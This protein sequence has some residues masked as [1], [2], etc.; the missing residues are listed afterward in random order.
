MFPGLL[1]CYSSPVSSPRISFNR[2]VLSYWSASSAVSGVPM[3]SAADFGT[4]TEAL[5]SLFPLGPYAASGIQDGEGRNKESFAQGQARGLLLGFPVG[6]AARDHVLDLL[7]R[8]AGQLRV[9]VVGVLFE[10]GQN[11][12]YGVLVQDSKLGDSVVCDKVRHFGAVVVVVL[13]LN[14]GVLAARLVA[15]KAPGVAAYNV[16]AAPAHGDGGSPP[17]FP[18]YA[19]QHLHLCLRVP[20]RVP[21][22]RFQAVDLH[23]LVIR[24]VYFEAVRRYLAGGG[25]VPLLGFS[26]ILKPPC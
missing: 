11:P 19:G 6:L 24:A 21:G 25:V 10:L 8:K 2:A 13:P 9:Q 14:G 23:D 4:N 26:F 7:R 16:A 22:V 3:I 20:V 1:R 18:D 5:P 15:C 12:G 17:L